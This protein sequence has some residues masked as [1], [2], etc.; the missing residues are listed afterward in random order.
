ML[1]IAKFRESKYVLQIWF[2]KNESFQENRL[3]SIFRR[4]L[5]KQSISI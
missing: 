4:I 3:N 1:Y 5:E 2:T